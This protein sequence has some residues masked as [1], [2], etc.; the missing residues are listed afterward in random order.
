MNDCHLEI[1]DCQPV[2]PSTADVPDH[3]DQVPPPRPAHHLVLLHQHLPPLALPA[4]RG[5]GEVILPTVLEHLQYM[6]TYMGDIPLS[7]PTASLEGEIRVLQ[8]LASPH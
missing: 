3:P 1:L 4:L 5:K 2:P 8:Y 6:C 7:Q